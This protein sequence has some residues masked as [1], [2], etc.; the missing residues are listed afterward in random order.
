MQNEQIGMPIKKYIDV[1][2]TSEVIVVNKI[3]KFSSKEIEDYKDKFKKLKE[4][5]TIVN[6]EFEDNEW[7]I[8]KDYGYTTITFDFEIN[9]ELNTAMKCYSVIKLSIKS[10]TALNISKSLKAI[11]RSLLLTSFFK[12]DYIIDYQN[13]FSSWSDTKKQGLYFVKEFI[14]YY[15][16]NE[17]NEYLKVINKIKIPL[18]N[19]R[20]LPSYKSILLFDAILEDF[21]KNTSIEQKQ[22]F[23][24]LLLWWK[25]TK[26]IPMRPCEFAKLGRDCCKYSEDTDEYYITIKRAKRKNGVIKYKKIPILNKIKTTKE[27][28]DLTQEYLLLVDPENKSKRLLS[29]N[30]YNKFLEPAFRESAYWKKVDSDVMTTSDLRYLLAKFYNEVV[31]DMYNFTCIDKGISNEK[32]EDYEI[33]RIQ[34]GDTRHLA[35]CSMMLQGFNP[36]TIAQIGGHYSLRGQMHYYS[37]LETFVD[38]HTYVLAK[39]LRDRMTTFSDINEFYT[40]HSTDIIEREKLGDEFYRL[41]KVEGGRCKSTNFPHDCKDLDHCIFCNNYIIDD[42]LTVELLNDISLKVEKEIASKLYYIKNIIKEFA[43]NIDVTENKVEYDLQDQERLKTCSNTLNTLVNQ[44]AVIDAFKL[45]LKD[46]C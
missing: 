35:F 44:K 43:F 16:I 40:K 1:Q 20:L 41:R 19:I 45:T 18:T 30:S 10:E 37:H 33:E 27:T 11:K 23:F 38:A 8:A 32:L 39:V 17:S 6:G 34:L 22:R 12:K 2:N 9:I 15:E 28:Y 13:S 46:K 24:P 31:T 21:Y 42:T 4:D 36:L 26:I 5:S 29:Y 3:V 7:T 25:I 14:K